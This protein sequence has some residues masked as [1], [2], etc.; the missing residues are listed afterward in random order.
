MG[1]REE[2]TL[3]YRNNVRKELHRK[4]N[5]ETNRRNHLKGLIDST[6]KERGV[7]PDGAVALKDIQGDCL[8]PLRFRWNIY[9]GGQRFII[10][11]EEC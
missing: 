8:E 11:D 5:E 10:N 2:L 1:I 6:F 4:R 3:E 7:K 9:G